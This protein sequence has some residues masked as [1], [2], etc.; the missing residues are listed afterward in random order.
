MA[1][2]IALVNLL[3]SIVPTAVGPSIEGSATFYAAVGIVAL[4]IGTIF[5]IRVSPAFPSV[6]VDRPGS[7][8]ANGFALSRGSAWRLFWIL[9]LIGLAVSIPIAGILVAGFLLF[10]ISMMGLAPGPDAA[11]ILGRIIWSPAL[12]LTQLIVAAGWG[13]VAATWASALS[14]FY[15]AV[16]GDPR[17]LAAA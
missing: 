14:H 11:A 4:I 9:L 8:I 16:A 6:A 10:G 17:T 7:W 1:F 3:A 12:L 2:S 5:A 13:L 15:R